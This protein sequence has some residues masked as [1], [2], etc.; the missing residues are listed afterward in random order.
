MRQAWACRAACCRTSVSP[1][2]PVTEVVDDAL[3]DDRCAAGTLS[4]SFL[5]PAGRSLYARVDFALVPGFGGFVDDLQ[6][7]F[8]LPRSS[9][10]RWR[11]SNRRAGAHA[12]THCVVCA[13]EGVRGRRS[14]GLQ[15]ERHGG[16]DVRC[17]GAY[18]LASVP[19][20]LP[21]GRFVRCTCAISAAPRTRCAAGPLATSGQCACHSV[22]LPQQGALRVPCLCGTPAPCFCAPLRSLVAADAWQCRLRVVS[23]GARRGA[24]AHVWVTDALLLSLPARR[25]PGPLWRV[26]SCARPVVWKPA[27]SCNRVLAATT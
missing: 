26:R 12:R 19:S 7:V 21:L 15:C 18:A 2:A 27:R 17:V 5:D 16:G 24:A 23:W 25:L 9:S 3:D 20:D 11:A 4:L 13:G 8:V 14:F 22:T 10:V 1:R 6:A